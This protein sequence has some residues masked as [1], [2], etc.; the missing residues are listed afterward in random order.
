[1][2]DLSFS[3]SEL[4]SGELPLVAIVGRPN[5]GKSTLFNRM[6]GKRKAITDP[7]P[8][9]TRDP[10]YERFDMDGIP[11]VLVDTGGYKPDM[12]VLDDLVVERSMEI[13]QSADLILLVTDVTEIQGEDE[14]L[15]QR[16]RP[17][18]KRIMLVVNKVDN[19][20][21]E[22]DVWNFYSL[23]FENVVPL[24]AAHGSNFFELQE[25]G[26]KM[27]KELSPAKVASAVENGGAGSDFD[28]E[29]ATIRI[30]ILGQ[31]NTG[32]STLNNILTGEGRS[33]VSDIP[34]TTR[35]IIEGSFAYK[36]RN[37]S[38]TDTAGIRRKKK[39][40]ENIE[41]YSVNR[42]ISSIDD[43]DVVLLMI[44]ADKGL[45]EQDKKIAN[46]IVRQ[47]RGVILVLNK[48]DLLPDI[49]NQEEA[50][51][52][53]IRFLFPILG[54]APMVPVS[55][56]EQDGI[57]RLL[58][59]VINVYGQMNRRVETSALNKALDDWLYDYQPPG[60]QIRYKV[61]YITQAGTNPVHF[62]LFVNRVKGFP[63]DWVQYLKNRLRKDLGFHSIPIRVD[64]KDSGGRK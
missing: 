64:L 18:S 60:R 61:K 2:K 39:V 48:W 14:E 3:P 8:G 31:P 37:F 1:M 9:V 30:S 4:E 22:E 40:G 29:T 42:A 52:D 25:T 6:I 46:L 23:G 43:C 13:L 16:L 27:L 17:Y 55:A 57:G 54:F 28:P 15:V 47:G 56:L 11:V 41:Y 32:K 36:G 26:G 21:R 10:V 38:V 7:T 24:S 50:V 58:N 45:S 51:K 53:R 20:T 63:A 35:D 44:D 5:V 34:G 49:S 59:T 19:T 62:I 12:E 33:I